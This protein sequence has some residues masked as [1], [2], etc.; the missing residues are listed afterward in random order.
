MTEYE[1]NDAI[2]A[3]GSN[4]IASE[5]LFLTFLS[6]YAVVAF[7]VG[8]RLTTYQI[9]FINF[10][11]VAFM[12]TSLGGLY[13]GVVQ[14]YY[15]G[16]ELANLRGEIMSQTIGE[17]VKWTMILTRFVMGLGALGFMW[18]VRHSKSEGLL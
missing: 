11:F 15:Y 6:A 4:L 16:D 10:V 3:I 9:V 1:L 2:Q 18:Q 13:S 14:A 7:T 12:V 5:A 17:T 8:K